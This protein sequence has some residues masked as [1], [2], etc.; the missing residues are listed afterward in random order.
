MSR[1]FCKLEK[2]P[3]I[4]C[5]SEFRFDTNLDDNIAFAIIF[6][7]LKS[8]SDFSTYNVIP[9]PIMQLPPEVR[10]FDAQL[11]FQPCYLLVK[12]NLTIGVSSHSLMFSIKAPYSSFKEFEEFIKL[13]LKAFDS[14]ILKKIYRASLRYI[15]KIP[16]S[17]FDATKLSI[18]GVVLP[19]TADNTIKLR[20]E[21]QKENSVTILLQLN[22]NT[23]I[24]FLE[25]GKMTE[26]IKAS[27][28]DIDSIYDF[29]YSISRFDDNRLI[30]ALSELHDKTHSVFFDLLKPEYIKCHFDKNYRN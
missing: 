20:I 30:E 4:E 3:I 6:Q 27:V 2:D 5:V 8:S 21:S 23:L 28:V 10:K 7:T 14:K 25:N 11:K 15:N 13:A 17:L 29:E 26:S 9:Q 1:E 24:S 12:N 19:I 16:D 22:N 18:N